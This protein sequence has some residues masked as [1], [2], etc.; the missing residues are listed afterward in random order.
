MYL[1]VNKQK[2]FKQMIFVWVFTFMNGSVFGYLAGFLL[3]LPIAPLLYEIPELQ[4]NVIALILILALGIPHG[5]IDNQLYLE[6][7]SISIKTFYSFYLGAIAANALIWIMFPHISFLLFIVISSYHFGQS[8]FCSL[9]VLNRKVKTL[10]Y[11]SW[12][13]LILSI[14]IFFNIRELSKVILAT[15][16]LAGF[17]LIF[18]ENIFLYVALIS[19]FTFYSLFLYMVTQKRVTLEKFLIESIIILLVTVT[20]FLFPFLVSFMLFFIM[21][22]SFKVIQEEFRYFFQKTDYDSIVNFLNKL[23]PLTLLSFAGIIII[24]FGIESDIIHISYPLVL[25]MLISSITLPHVV[26]MERFYAKRSAD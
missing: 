1:H 3:L 8:Q 12:G 24:V 6:K 9:P 2:I 25:L 23:L 17:D 21:I 22:H 5:A 16:D 19:C 18:R 13:T 10:F 4:L 26:V 7:S 14:M 20:S 11:I 15:D